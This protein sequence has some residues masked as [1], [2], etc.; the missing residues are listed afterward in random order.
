MR[1]G[2]K[3]G[4]IRVGRT[5][6]SIFPPPGVP[7]S[8]TISNP[9]LF[10]GG[11]T[12]VTVPQVGEGMPSIKSHS[13]SMTNLYSPAVFTGNVASLQSVLKAIYLPVR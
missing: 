3:S 10:V 12:C 9:A 4:I 2:R 6:R 5:L 11:P 8:T 7:A 13:S 1:N